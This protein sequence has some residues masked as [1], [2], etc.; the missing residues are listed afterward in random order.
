LS[1]EATSIHPWTLFDTREA[2][3]IKYIQ[4]FGTKSIESMA[5]AAGTAADQ[6]LWVPAW[7]RRQPVAA[8]A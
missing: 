4:E 6:A 7:K 2:I 5:G 1:G 3:N 8:L